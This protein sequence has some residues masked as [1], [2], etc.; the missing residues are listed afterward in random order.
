[1]D[2]VYYVGTPG[3]DIFFHHTLFAGCRA[4]CDTINIYY[5]TSK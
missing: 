4:G 3:Q 2:G 1:M 5:A